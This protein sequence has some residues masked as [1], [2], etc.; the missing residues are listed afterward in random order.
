MRPRRRGAKRVEFGIGDVPVI[1][2]LSEPDHTPAA[3]DEQIT[4]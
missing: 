1:V 4:L 2:H 3:K